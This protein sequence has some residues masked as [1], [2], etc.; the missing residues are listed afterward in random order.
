MRADSLKRYR[1]GEISDTQLGAEQAK[2]DYLRGN[3][4]ESE[5]RAK[6]V[7]PPKGAFGTQS[8]TASG[9]IA[10]TKNATTGPDMENLNAQFSAWFATHEFAIKVRPEMVGAEGI[11]IIA[12]DTADKIGAQE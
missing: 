8:N 1:S 11:D 3:I 2:V 4:S 9:A 10:A 7:I 12:R 6:E 5:L